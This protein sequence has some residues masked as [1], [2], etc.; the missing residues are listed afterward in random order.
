MLLFILWRSLRLKIPTNATFPSTASLR[1]SRSGSAS[2]L[3]SI[4]SFHPSRR[5]VVSFR[6]SHHPWKMRRR[7]FSSVSSP[8]HS[9]F[10]FPSLRIFF[11]PFLAQKY[12]SV[13]FKFRRYILIPNVSSWRRRTGC[14]EIFTWSP[15]IGPIWT[16]AP[17]DSLEL[18]LAWFIPP[19]CSLWKKGGDEFQWGG[20]RESWSVSNK[21]WEKI[22]LDE[23][24]KCLIIIIWWVIES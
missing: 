6:W 1:P 3:M 22:L 2:T 24:S 9:F 5:G 21:A 19:A 15:T 16:F 23:V 18:F 10:F 13:W 14:S 8:S 17:E 4:P 7:Y 11:S 20:R 12:V